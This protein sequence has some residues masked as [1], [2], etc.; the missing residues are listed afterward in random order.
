MTK[1]NSTPK[2]QIPY[3]PTKAKKQERKKKLQN[4]SNTFHGRC[5]EVFRHSTPYL[6]STSRNINLGLISSITSAAEY[7]HGERVG[8]NN[9]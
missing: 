4:I 7:V 9:I 2:Q 6:F 3:I 1:W 5:V 8:R